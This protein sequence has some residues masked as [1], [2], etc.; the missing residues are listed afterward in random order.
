MK[1]TSLSSPHREVCYRCHKPQRVCICALI[2]PVDNTTGITILQ[3]PLERFHPIGTARIAQLALSQVDLRIAWNRQNDGASL[4]ADI[5]QNAGLLFPGPNARDLATVPP[6]E[7]PEHLVVLDGTWSTVKSIYR[8]NPRLQELPHFLLTPDAPGQYRIR[9]EP[10]EN[11][12]S[13][14][15][16]IWQAIR[17]LEPQN[18]TVHRLMDAFQAMIHRQ[19]QFET[20]PHRRPRTNTRPRRPSRAIPSFFAS[21]FENVVVGYGE[22]VECNKA[23]GVYHL[24]YWA[25][26]RPATGESFVAAIH[27]GERPDVELPPDHHTNMELP[28]AVFEQGITLE[29]FRQQWASFMGP[30]D[31]LGLWSQITLDLFESIVPQTNPPLFLKGI[32]CNHL[33]GR[34]GNLSRVLEREGLEPV[35]LPAQGRP[36]FRLGNA[37]AVTRFLHDTASAPS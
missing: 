12:R 25:A 19:E 8:D 23:P 27:P 34:S 21:H 24:L 1:P 4:T 15:E 3:H 37:A 9:K 18:T 10:K 26:F 11:Y 20:S 28:E 6:A 7:R 30:E 14:I 13:T 33:G 36:A 35:T 29:A 17:I 16:A 22:F 32:Y 2:A 31:R 5:P